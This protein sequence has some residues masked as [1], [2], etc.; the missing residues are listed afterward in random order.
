MNT[1]TDLL[2]DLKQLIF[3]AGDAIMAIYHDQSQWNTQQKTNDTPVTAADLAAQTILF[4]GLIALT[5]HLPVL[6]EEGHIAD[7]ETRGSW[8]TYWLLDPLDGTRE[9]LQ[10]NGEFTVNIALIEQGR[11]TLGLVYVPASGT[12]YWGTQ[13]NGAWKCLRDGIEAPIH[14]RETGP[15][16]RLLTSRR[17][18]QHE[19]AVLEQLMDRGIYSQINSASLGSSLKFCQIADGQADLYLRLAPTSEWDTGA[20]QAILEAAGGILLKL[21][22]GTPLM[23][24]QK[25]SLTNPSFIAMAK[26]VP[27]WIALLTPAES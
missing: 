13:N 22:D 25:E 15:E 19:T 12:L 17:H 6:S 21:P 8:N 3:A 9:F 27:D 10:R 1:F 7:W 18:S 5:P 20:A 16:C 23:Y 26:P 11:P 24:N 14:V 4:K 2:P